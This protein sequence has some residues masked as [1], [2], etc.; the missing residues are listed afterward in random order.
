M[1]ITFIKGK[2][3]DRIHVVR[4]DGSEAAATL[5]QK[6]PVPH[7]AFHY[8]VERAAG[9]TRGFWGLVAAG[10][11]PDEISEI[12]RKAGHPSAKRGEVPA[13]AFVQA[14]QTER[15]VEAFEAD[16]WSGGGDP[17]GVR[18]MATSGCWQ[19]H[20]A[21]PE[22]PDATILAIQKSLADFTSD[23][24]ALP[25]GGSRSVDWEA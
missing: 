25:V 8:F 6:G 12:A 23:W 1:R 18:D 20:V 7:D 24:M 14:I 15:I 22:L 19:S 16:Q 5:P 9:F 11:H 3:S 2:G 17:Q 4:T 21:M 13:D 10:H